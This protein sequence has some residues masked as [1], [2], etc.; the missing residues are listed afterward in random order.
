[1]T[2]FRRTRIAYRI[3][4]AICCVLGLIVLIN[5]ITADIAD[6]VRNPDNYLLWFAGIALFVLFL[7]AS[8]LLGV[9]IKDGQDDLETLQRYYDDK[10]SSKQA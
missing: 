6:I 9:I 3:V 4:S 2:F 8:I 7:F 5:V 10:L 1:M